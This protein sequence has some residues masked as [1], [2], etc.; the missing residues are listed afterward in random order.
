MPTISASSISEAWKKVV[1]ACIA[2]RGHEICALTVEILCGDGPMDDLAFRES[3]N[4][5]LIAENR[6][7]VETVARTIFPIGLWNPEVSRS[8]LYKR[9][10]NILPKLRKCPLNRR[11]IYFERLIDYHAVKKGK[12]FTNQLEFIINTYVAK[13]NHRRSALQATLYNPL[14]H[15]SHSRRLGFPCLQQIAFIPNKS[16][17]LTVLGFYPVH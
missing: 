17:E 16:R 12:A 11:G 9:Y 8:N 4:K 14:I 7:S 10:S 3:V 6:G 1:S 13:R 5:I 15:A 2:A